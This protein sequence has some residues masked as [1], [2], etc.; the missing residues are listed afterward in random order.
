[1]KQF[2]KYF[3]RGAFTLLPFGLTVLILISFLAWVDDLSRKA[4][5][6][7]G[8]E[9]YFPG[10]GLIIGISLVC[11]LGFLTTLPFTATILRA[12]ELPFRNVPILK[13]IY[14]AV[15]NL[16]DYFS[17]GGTGSEQQVVVVRVPGFEAEFMGLV[18]RRNLN[19][20]PKEFSRENRVA[21]FIPLSYQVGGIT[22]FIPR[23]YV[24]KTDLKVEF[25]MKSA[26]T[27]WLPNREDFEK[28]SD[29]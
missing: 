9:F 16:S 7:W 15:K 10:L 3:L 6:V 22:V 14:S 27:A 17:P 29:F 4:F 26:L 20:M 13:S 5:A 2:S 23:A 28:I 8:S 25:A 12:I 11:F 18:T 19:D 1:V 21:V 24:T